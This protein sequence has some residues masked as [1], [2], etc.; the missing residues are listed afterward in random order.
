LYAG[1]ESVAFAPYTGRDSTV[2]RIYA[3]CL[4]LTL[5][6]LATT[7]RKWWAGSSP[8]NSIACD[9]VGVIVLL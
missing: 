9:F 4:A 8:K 6:S 1:L 3:V 5:S 2:P 7:T